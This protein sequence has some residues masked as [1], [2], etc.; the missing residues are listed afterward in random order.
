MKHLLEALN[1]Y[2]GEKEIDHSILEA[3]AQAV[4]ADAWSTGPAPGYIDMLVKT[5]NGTF[6]IARLEDNPCLW[7]DKWG[8]II[9]D[10]IAWRAL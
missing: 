5:T 8:H 2:F 3:I 4:D 1:L 9:L 7:V 6:H 10:V